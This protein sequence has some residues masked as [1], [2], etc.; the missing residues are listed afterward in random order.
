MILEIRTKGP[1]QSL[2]LDRV[3]VLISN[4]STILENRTKRPLQ[5]WNFEVVILTV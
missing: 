3:E 4:N 5:F 1:M 2:N